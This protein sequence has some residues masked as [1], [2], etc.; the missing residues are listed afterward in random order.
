MRILIAVFFLICG[1]VAGLNC[2]QE[3]SIVTEEVV[4]FE[5]NIKEIV[6]IEEVVIGEVSIKDIEK[7][8][9]TL[10]RARFSHQY[11]IDHPEKLPEAWS[12]SLPHHKA[13]VERY[14]QVIELLESLR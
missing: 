2:P 5:E 10:R 8:L 14:D 4:V 12:D 3:V 9:S 7:S 11:Y 6:V 13:C 1:F